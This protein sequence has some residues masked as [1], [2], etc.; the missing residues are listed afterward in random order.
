[1]YY[2][3]S[4]NNWRRDALLPGSYSQSVSSGGGVLRDFS[5]EIDLAQWLFDY[6]KVDYAHGAKVGEYMIDGEDLVNIVMSGNKNF[7]ISIHLNSLQ[8]NP[9]RLIT[10]R[11]TEI[12]Y[13][14][15]LVNSVLMYGDIVERFDTNTD[16]SY[17]KMHEAIISGD[18]TKLASIKDGLLVDN[19]IK[20]VEA[21]YKV[22]I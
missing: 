9:N 10:I 5:H 16:H 12:D 8:R 13:K 18:K 14:L 15:D 20:D 4:T 7:K 21:L 2:G 22:G 17:Q 1:M 6:T 19:I 3:N 11:T